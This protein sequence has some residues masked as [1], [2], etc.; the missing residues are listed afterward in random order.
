M[1]V[2]NACS[3]GIY[4]NKIKAK[5]IVI[6]SFE[7]IVSNTKQKS[8]MSEYLLLVTVLW[9]DGVQNSEIPI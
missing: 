5:I 4:C 7:E 1:Q 2:I 9:G 8:N 6:C 3:F